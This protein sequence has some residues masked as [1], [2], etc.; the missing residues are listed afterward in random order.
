MVK[1]HEK[2]LLRSVM[3]V[4]F[5]NQP[6]LMSVTLFLEEKKNYFIL[7]FSRMTKVRLNFLPLM[8]QELIA[9]KYLPRFL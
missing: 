5:Y 9:N 8:I 3:T 2:G 1:V 7:L 6:K 4:Y